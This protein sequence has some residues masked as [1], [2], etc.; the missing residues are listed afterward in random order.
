[1]LVTQDSVFKIQWSRSVYYLKRTYNLLVGQKESGIGQN[2]NEWQR[3]IIAILTTRMCGMG[4]ISKDSMPRSPNRF[5]FCSN[6]I[7]KHLISTEGS[8][9]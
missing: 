4:R 1:M 6:S 2:I 9:T 3:R 5:V 8:K 7:N